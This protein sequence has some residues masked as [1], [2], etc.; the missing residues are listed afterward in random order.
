VLDAERLELDDASVDGVL[1]R[2]GLMLMADPGRALREARRVLRDGGRLGVAVFDAA[3]RNP[4][5]TVARSVM[6]ERGHLPPPDPDEPGIFTL[7]DPAR[8]RALLGAAG[9]SDADVEAMD[10]AFRFAD[11]DALWAYTRDLQGPVAL[12]IARLPDGERR[13]VRA[14]LEEGYADYRRDGGYVLPGRTLNVV[15]R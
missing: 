6:V 9:F 8:I 15:A 3:E 12:A 14:A 11:A 2:F 1:C 4:W 7:G 13:A 10:V 5:L